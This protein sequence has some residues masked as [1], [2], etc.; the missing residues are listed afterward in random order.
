MSVQSFRELVLPKVLDRLDRLDRDAV[1]NYLTGLLRE[2]NF[3]RS[4]LNSIREAV[5]FCDSQG[6]I[7]NS[8][9]AAHQLLGIPEP[10]PQGDPVS[11]YI[12]GP[13]WVTALQSSSPFHTEFLID[14]P[15]RRRVEIQVVPIK[16]LP[17]SVP[18]STPPPLGE[19][20]GF[21]LIVREVSLNLDDLREVAAQERLQAVVSLAAGIAHEI[22]NP[23]NS[24]HIQLQ[25]LKRQL[26][27]ARGKKSIGLHERVDIALNEIQRLNSVLNQFLK[28]VRPVRPQLRP[29]SLSVLV[30]DT[31]ISMQ[32][33][34]DAREII[35]EQDLQSD[36]PPVM[37]DP[38]QIRQVLYNLVRNAIQASTP[39][40][41]L[42]VSTRRTARGAEFTVKDNGC[43][44]TP[45]VMARAFDPY[46]TTKESG[47]GL[48]LYIVRR[49]VQAHGG[50][51][52]VR[53]TEGHGTEITVELPTECPPLRLAPPQPN[54][55]PNPIENKDTPTKNPLYT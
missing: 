23:L 51:I 13:D 16:A 35:L 53:S 39:K 27:K 36:L 18:N 43:G 42:Q 3:A 4:A 44:M 55:H 32:P 31:L 17:T 25:L 48:G 20:A 24:L 1:V 34:L 22:G 47:H 33:E 8:N 7:L 14:Y 15:I 30:A 11:K 50:E 29:C 19:D 26:P 41:I 52:K 12:R 21:I 28:A 45:E 54:A 38:D 49:I 40:S 37:A 5:V 2:L 6:N 46:F 9:P 10:L